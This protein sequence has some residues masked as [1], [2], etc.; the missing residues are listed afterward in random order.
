VR[1]LATAGDLARV[2]DT[3][4]LWA[5]DGDWTRVGGIAEEHGRELA[6]VAADE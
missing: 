5:D 4:L 1:T 6:R 3:W 2:R